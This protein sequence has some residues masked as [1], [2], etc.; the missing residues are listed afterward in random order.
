MIS[1]IGIKVDMLRSCSDW[2]VGEA[3]PSRSFVRQFPEVL[4]YR[5]RVCRFFNRGPT[6]KSDRYKNVYGS[7]TS[8]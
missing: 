5:G 8:L 6:I 2:L 1:L 4:E 7:Y 3:A